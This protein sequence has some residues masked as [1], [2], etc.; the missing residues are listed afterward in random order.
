MTKRA[1]KRRGCSSHRSF[2][3]APPLL[4]Q[5][6]RGYVTSWRDLLPRNFPRTRTLKGDIVPF[7]Q[8]A[9][10]MEQRTSRR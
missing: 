6:R 1:R 10:C 9:F 4:L 8:M 7:R 5:K 3:S 2:D